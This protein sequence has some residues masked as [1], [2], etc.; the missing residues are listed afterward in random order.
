[1]NNLAL[2]SWATPL[3]LQSIVM[4]A[5]VKSRSGAQ[6]QMVGQPV[7]GKAL[8]VFRQHHCLTNLWWNFSFC[9]KIFN[10]MKLYIYD[11]S[12]FLITN[13]FINEVK[14]KTK[15]WHKLCSI[16]CKERQSQCTWNVCGLKMSVYCLRTLEIYLPFVFLKAYVFLSDETNPTSP[17]QA[18][19]DSLITFLCF[20]VRLN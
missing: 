9:L 5:A 19:V 3:V 10:E 6:P 18:R 11:E 14:D 17:S 12:L 15:I 8:E 20:P 13:K 1:M 16:S 7:A 2:N 4:A